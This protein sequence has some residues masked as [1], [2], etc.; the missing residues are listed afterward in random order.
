LQLYAPLKNV[1]DKAKV[2]SSE[3]LSTY[4]LK[5]VAEINTGANY[6]FNTVEELSEIA[7]FESNQSVIQNQRINIR[8]FLKDIADN[9]N[10]EN[11]VKPEIVKLNIDESVPAQINVDASRLKN[12]INKILKIANSLSIEKN[13]NLS[14]SSQNDLFNFSIIAEG[15]GFKSFND[16]VLSDPFE[17]TNTELYKESKVTPLEI[18]ILLNDLNIFRGKVKIVRSDT[19]KINLGFYI[20]GD[21]MPESKSNNESVKIEENGRN[22]VL[23]IEDD[24]ATAELLSK[25]LLEWGYKP[26]V[27]NTTEETL[28]AVND[29]SFIVIILDIELPEING[30]ELLKNIHTKTKNKFTPVIVC[31]V[32]PEN[33]Q[34]MMIGTVDFFEKPINYGFLVEAL[35]HYKLNKN[36]KILCV[37]DDIPT[38][39]LI[40]KTIETAG[41]NCIAE[42]DSSKVMESINNMDMN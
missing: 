4:Q 39:N 7:A 2:L 32:K 41:Y 37:D 5:F 42:N 26:L 6:A 17:I 18:Q 12:V 16:L 38:L 33:Q 15:K 34:A 23:V 31:S 3:Y 14:L 25:Y 27:V 9:F 8:E 13:L 10:F 28:E 1:V 21:N 20:T 40:S 11:T 35:E 29:Q 19:G 24:Y 30:L 36:S 22:K